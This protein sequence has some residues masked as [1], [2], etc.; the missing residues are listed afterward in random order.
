MLKRLLIALAIPPALLVL[1]IAFIYINTFW[2]SWVGVSTD[3]SISPML[4]TKPQALREPVT[5]KVVTFNIQDLLVVARDHEDR[6]RA[7]AAK[8]ATLDPDI[9]G[10]QEAFIEDHRDLLIEELKRQTRL[11]HFQYYPSAK[12]GSGLLTASAYPI[13]EHYFFRFPQSN[14]W[15]K[16]WEGD[17]WAGKGAGLARIEVAPDSIIDFYNT[18]AQADYGV[19][20]NTLIRRAQLTGLGQ[21]IAQSRLGTVPAILVGDLNSRPG[22]DEYNAVIT[23]AN[24][25]R[26][27]NVDSRIDH[28]LTT[29][30][31]AYTVEVL[32]SIEIQERVTT[33]TKSFHLSDHNGYMSTLKLIPRTTTQTAP[34][35]NPANP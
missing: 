4:H 8:L 18:H 20:A 6:M 24:L 29:S 30:D 17:Y 1:L 32:D 34:D 14:P 27:M 21:F 19:P 11:Q 13:R 25:I 12:V 22:S 2:N 15:W 9:V 23:G 7:I 26:T 5:L 28:I 10:F 33:S 31:P 16:L 3:F 35:P